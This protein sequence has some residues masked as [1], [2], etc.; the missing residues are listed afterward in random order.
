MRFAGWL[1]LLAVAGC[2]DD[3]GD[4]PDLRVSLTVP[5]TSANGTNPSFLSKY[6]GT[7]ITIEIVMD[8]ASIAQ[9]QSATCGETTAY[10]IEA[11]RTAT[12]ANAAD[13]TTDLLD[14]L[15][16]WSLTQEICDDP[17]TS[18][19]SLVGTI[20]ELNLSF[21]CGT[22]PP[23]AQ[24]RGSDGFPRIDSFTATRCNAIIL[25]VVNAYSL[26]NTGPTPTDFPMTITTGHSLP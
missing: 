18:S 10:A 2:G 25:D 12:G 26:G 24:V 5:I 19:V 6:V 14:K 8:P 15:P 11:V 17:S 13:V 3:G 16:A 21:G 7:S 9:D 1:C 22:I 20:N 23:S 4:A